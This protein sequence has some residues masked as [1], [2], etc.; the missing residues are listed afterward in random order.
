MR[1]PA[2]ILTYCLTF[3][4]RL[5]RPAGYKPLIA[6]NLLMEQQVSIISRTLYRSPCLKTFDR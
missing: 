2:V 1:S 5:S 6:E 3:L 4:V